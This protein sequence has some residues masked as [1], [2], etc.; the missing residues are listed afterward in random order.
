MLLRWSPERPAVCVCV[1]KCVYLC[2][3]GTGPDPPFTAHWL[4]TLPG[5][6]HQLVCY[7]TYQT[8]TCRRNYGMSV[9]G[10]NPDITRRPVVPS[11][12]YQMSTSRGNCKEFLQVRSHTG[13]LGKET[14]KVYCAEL[15]FL[16]RSCQ[17]CFWKG[18]VFTRSVIRTW[19]FY[20]TSEC[21]LGKHWA[22][23]LSFALN[24]ERMLTD[25]WKMTPPAQR[26]SKSDGQLLKEEKQ[27]IIF[28]Q[29]RTKMYK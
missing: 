22:H 4:N 12:N 26:C 11:S 2:L 13:G 21:S 28:L 17:L 27:R 20:H 7:A 10:P 29:L 15:P 5:Q 18:S 14:L 9:A 3:C 6:P 8:D 19:R 23:L 1:Y 24:R 25:V 16:M